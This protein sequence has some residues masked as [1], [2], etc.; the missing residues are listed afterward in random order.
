MQPE[1]VA[2]PWEALASAKLIRE[3]VTGRTQDDY[4]DDV[5]L[6]DRVERRFIRIGEALSQASKLDP[7]LVHKLPVLPRIV[8]FPTTRW[9]GR[10]RT[11][12]STP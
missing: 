7:D 1:V 6:R 3:Y 8:A 9:C 10:W 11:I 12:S 2:H 5:G 4:R